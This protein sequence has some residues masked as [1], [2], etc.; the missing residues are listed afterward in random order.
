MEDKEDIIER[1]KTLEKYSHA[2]TD[3][4][5]KINFLAKRVKKLSKLITDLIKRR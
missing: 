3:W 5:E 2:P 1:I 4:E